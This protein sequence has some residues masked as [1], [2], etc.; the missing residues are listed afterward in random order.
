MAEGPTSGS[1]QR[2]ETRPN[3]GRPG[4]NEGLGR[5]RSSHL[6]LI[7]KQRLVLKERTKEIREDAVSKIRGVAE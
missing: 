1:T 7:L 4:G 2:R 5:A 6:K 3:Q